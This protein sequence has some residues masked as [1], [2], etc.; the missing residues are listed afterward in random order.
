MKISET[1]NTMIKNISF[2]IKRRQRN[3]TNIISF[4]FMQFTLN[5]LHIMPTKKFNK[6][7]INIFFLS[8]VF[9]NIFFDTFCFLSLFGIYKR[10][11]I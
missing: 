2:I 9:Q 3:F 1:M 6:Q 11:D 8:Y 7:N 5:P 4:N 10:I